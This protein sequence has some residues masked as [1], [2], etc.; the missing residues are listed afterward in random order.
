MKHLKLNVI[1]G[2]VCLI[3]ALTASTPLASKASASTTK[4]VNIGTTSIGSVSY[5]ITAG[6]ADF[7]TKYAG[8]SA[9]AEASGGAD[10]NVRLLRR[11]DTDLVNRTTR[12][13]K[14]T[15]TNAIGS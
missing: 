7:V 4:S 14:R 2:F 15:S 3:L 9:T 11:G 13:I 6:F 1:L 12:R 5:V 8:I 10:A